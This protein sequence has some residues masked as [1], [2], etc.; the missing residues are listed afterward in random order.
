E[1]D[2]LDLHLRR[3]LV[4]EVVKLLFREVTYRLVRIKQ[5]RL[6]KDPRCPPAI[7]LVAGDGD[8]ALGERLGVVEE[9]GEVDI[10][11]RAPALTARAHAAGYAEASSLG[12]AGAASDRD[13]TR[14]ADRGDAEG[15]RVGRADVRLPE[16]TEEDAQHPVR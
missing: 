10:G 12:L 11:D 8:R 7:H 13:R 14:P 4:E 3:V 1:V 5:T 6:D 9:L 15:E 2:A 16:S